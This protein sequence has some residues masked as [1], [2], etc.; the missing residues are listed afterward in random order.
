MS[1]VKVAVRVRPFNSREK[2]ANAALIIGMEGKS[3]KITDPV[4]EPFEPL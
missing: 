2:D 4:P 1:S 3:T